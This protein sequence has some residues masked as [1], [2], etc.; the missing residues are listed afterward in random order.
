M[1]GGHAGRQVGVVEWGRCVLKKY[2]SD[3]NSITTTSTCVMGGGEA[4]AL[5]DVLHIVCRCVVH[6][7]PLQAGVAVVHPGHIRHIV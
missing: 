3:K 5:M 2:L 1:A 7:H 4:D 6:L